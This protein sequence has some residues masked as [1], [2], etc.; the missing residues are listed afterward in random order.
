VVSIRR[1][2]QERGYSTTSVQ[3]AIEQVLEKLPQVYTDNLYKEKCG[4]VY[5]HVYDSY[6][7]V[8]ESVCAGQRL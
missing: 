7:G 5:Q 4:V 3:V 6:Y 8:G 2:E 1:K